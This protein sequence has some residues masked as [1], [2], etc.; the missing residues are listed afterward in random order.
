MNSA[1]LS[2]QRGGNLEAEVKWVSAQPHAITEILDALKRKT[3]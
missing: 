3:V 2:R 1:W